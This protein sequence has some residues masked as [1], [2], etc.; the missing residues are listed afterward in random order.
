MKVFIT[1]FALTGGII[2]K[3]DAEPCSSEGMIKVPS[4][5]PHVFFH[6][7]DGRDWHATRESAVKKA[8]EMR[9]KKIASI[10]KQLAK[11]ESMKF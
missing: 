2:E 3:D 10:K 5:G 8:E 4:M 11:L 6:G 7:G 1:R 9:A